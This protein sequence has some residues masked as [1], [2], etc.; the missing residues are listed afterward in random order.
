MLERGDPV[1]ARLTHAARVLQRAYEFQRVILCLK[2][3][4]TGAYRARVLVGKAPETAQAA[5]GFKELGAHDLFNAAVAQRADIYIRDVA[6]AKLQQNLPLWFKLTC[7]DAKSFLLLS[8]ASA[9]G[10]LGFF[11]ADHARA[12]PPGLT[13]EEVDIVKT[14]KQLTW[15]AVRQEQSASTMRQGA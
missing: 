8:I 4:A 1:E 12:N 7:P 2:D 15:V 13:H 3:A 14:L 6:D 10:T 5:F 9:D 11:Y